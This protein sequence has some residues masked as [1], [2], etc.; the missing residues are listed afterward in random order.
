MSDFA[1]SLN[2][3]NSP[4][5]K[6]K[7]LIDLA[8]ENISKKACFI[9]KDVLMLDGFRN[10]KFKIVSNDGEEAVYKGRLVKYYPDL[11]LLKQG[12]AIHKELNLSEAYELPKNKGYKAVLDNLL[13]S[14]VKDYLITYSTEVKCCEDQEGNFCSPSELIEAGTSFST[15]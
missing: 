5:E 12:N 7:I 15:C 1:L 10:N 11:I 4:S 14:Q 6:G 2:Y 13:G 3:K 8:L 9:S